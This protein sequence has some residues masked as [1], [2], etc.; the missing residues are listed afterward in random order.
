MSVEE[1]PLLTLQMNFE[2]NVYIGLATISKQKQQIKI[3]LPVRNGWI[4]QRTIYSQRG[5]GPV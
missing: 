5:V 1:M 2:R 4:L 3:K